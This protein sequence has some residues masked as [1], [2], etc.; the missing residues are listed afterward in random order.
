MYSVLSSTNA[1]IRERGEIF[2]KQLIYRKSSFLKIFNRCSKSLKFNLEKY[3]LFVL[4]QHFLLPFSIS[5]INII[6]NIL[7][8]QEYLEL[9]KF[10]GLIS[11]SI[12]PK[13][14]W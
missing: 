13:Y 11:R 3:R 10:L 8:L 7:K 5:K 6:Y 12:F 14:I 9:I 2:L 4:K 1:L